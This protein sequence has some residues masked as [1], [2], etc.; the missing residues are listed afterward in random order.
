MGKDICINTGACISGEH[1]YKV[2]CSECPYD[3]PD[4][5]CRHCLNS[6]ECR[7]R[8]F[9]ENC[10]SNNFNKFVVALR[11]PGEWVP[12]YVCSNCGHQTRIRES[13]CSKC[14]ALMGRR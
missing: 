3:R 4:D 11:P 10:A 5:R 12:G 13:E 2:S 14:H 9:R 1:Q 7:D 6:D 8:K